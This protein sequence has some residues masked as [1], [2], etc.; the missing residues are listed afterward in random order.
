MDTRTAF[1][2]MVII[3]AMLLALVPDGSQ[4]GRAAIGSLSFDVPEGWKVVMEPKRIIGTPVKASGG[5]FSE[6]FFLGPAADNGKELADNLTKYL[7]KTFADYTVAESKSFKL[8]LPAGI[9]NTGFSAK[10][11]HRKDRRALYTINMI[12]RHSG[13]LYFFTYDTDSDSLFR[14]FSKNALIR[15]MNAMQAGDKKDDTRGKETDPGTVRK[16]IA[17]FVLSVPANWKASKNPMPPN[18]LL[19]SVPA[20]PPVKG[21]RPFRALVGLYVGQCSAPEKELKLWTER[22]FMPAAYGAND[23]SITV[24]DEKITR[25]SEG[26]RDAIACTTVRVLFKGLLH[27][28]TTAFIVPFEGHSVLMGITYE[29]V[30]TINGNQLKKILATKNA[31]VKSMLRCASGT[32]YSALPRQNQ[33]EEF[34]AKKGIWRYSYDSQIGSMAGVYGI[35]V[36]NISWD[37]SRDGTCVVKSSDFSGMGFSVYS[38]TNPDRYLGGSHDSNREDGDLKSPYFVL[39]RGPSELWIILRP[40]NGMGTFHR[41]N[42]FAEGKFGEQ[43]IK[44][45][46]IDGR[47]EGT[48]TKGGGMLLWKP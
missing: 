33:W 45:V 21:L 16:S 39:G 37:F 27:S 47:I 5:S 35:T 3:A 38:V 24:R 30:E 36:R 12:L 17:G 13:A 22:T 32:T 8:A 48:Y 44:G 15:M 34:L 46:A 25:L 18:Q 41:L 40:R 43:A 2:A 6:F 26:G 28:H 11:L 9:E 10:V 1:R 42:P 31:V 19:F 14:N 7:E 29:H 20:G 4:A 23:G